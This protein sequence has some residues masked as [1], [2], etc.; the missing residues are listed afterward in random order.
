VLIIEYHIIVPGF[1]SI[2]GQKHPIRLLK[3]FL[4]NG[5]LPHA[6]LFTGIEGVG[7]RTAATEIA[8]AL[9]CANPRADKTSRRD[10][11]RACGICPAC[12]QI[13]SNSH[14]DVFT[15][16]PQN[17]LLRIDQIRKLIRTLAMKPF[18]A[19]HRVVTIAE[20]QTMNPEAANALLKI[21]E[22]PPRQTTLILTAP[23]RS[24]LLP[25][26]VSRCRQIAFEP[27]RPEELQILL[28][29]KLGTDKGQA[30]T[31]V[32]MAGGSYAKARKMADDTW[33]SQRRWILH[34]AGLDAPGELNNRPATVALAF[35]AQLAQHKDKVLDLLEML[36][37]WIRDLNIRPYQPERIIN[38]DREHLIDE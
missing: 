31:I 27:L 23:H 7:K 8:I 30:Q 34:A 37:T 29:D 17:N 26:I 18:S 6:L 1:D 32:A 2:I 36:Q 15:V 4:R 14:P 33:Q 25:T 9:N 28:A 13:R 20:A 10:P 22:E 35:S 38:R 16:T 24:E 5:T 21:L 11:S 12:R 3:R 19:R